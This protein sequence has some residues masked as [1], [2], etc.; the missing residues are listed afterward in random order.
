MSSLG[1]AARA[2]I[3]AL[4]V[5]GCGVGPPLASPTESSRPG[6]S[7]SAGVDLPT[8][9]PACPNLVAA[10]ETGPPPTDFSENGPLARDHDRLEADIE[11]AIAYGAAHQDEFAS[12]RWENSPRV[13]IVIG[14]TANVEEHC[15][16]LRAVFE[17][18][19]EFEIIRQP[20]TEAQMLAILDDLGTR[21]RDHLRSVGLGAG[22]ID[23][24]LRGD[25]ATI[26]DEVAAQYGDL[27]RITV[28]LLPYPDRF[29]GEPRCILAG[30]ILTDT[31]YR[32]TLS[33]PATVTSGEDFRGT[34]RVTNVSDAQVIL[35]TGQPLTAILFRA[36]SNR[37]VGFFDGAVGG[38]GFGGPLGPGEHLDIDVL[39]AT[40]SCDPALGYALPPAS[41]DVRA[42]VDQYAM[43]DNAPTEISYLLSE[44]AALTIVP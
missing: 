37:P 28:G 41:Y 34:A 10:V 11:A 30:P 24:A 21:Y 9:V 6:A 38:T 4:I 26:A 39:G 42:L 7:E 8:A 22:T 19:D 1:L 31:P 32:V 3:T 25:G 44:P 13:R 36:G 18:P 16:A 15:A 14:F 5:A 23:L 2:V 29:A 35:D 27:V 43:H 33:V 40:P 17:Y 20:A 12:V